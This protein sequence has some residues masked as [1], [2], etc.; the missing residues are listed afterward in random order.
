MAGARWAALAVVGAI[1]VGGVAGCG[2][3]DKPSGTNIAVV[4]PAARDDVDWSR[5]TTA[6]VEKTAKQFHV[7]AQVAEGTTD[8]AK[9]LLTRLAD[10]AQLVVAPY[11][12]DGPDAVAVATRT[13]VPAL[14]WGDP[15]A[16][17]PG[18][19]GDVEA[20][21]ASVVYGAGAVAV[22]AA[23]QRSVGI[24]ICDDESSFTMAERFDLAA[25]YVAG[26]RAAFPKAKADF[27]IA[28]GDAA[29]A[30]EAV[31]AVV[32]KGAQMVLSLCGAGAPGVMTGIEIA[33]RKIE[34]EAQLVTVIGDQGTINRE[35]MVLTG[36][37][38]HPEVAFA[39][40]IKDIRADRFG[41]RVYK[42]DMAN[43]GVTLLQTGRT[44]GDAYEVGLKV[45][46]QM[47]ALP[48]ASDE[49]QLKA[50]IDGSGQ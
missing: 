48:H 50:L 42:L 33:A 2:G 28:G 14:V 32:R 9:S 43:G 5:A 20:D 23:R 36:A 6:G 41:K 12:A 8:R 11:R 17:R 37:I 7:R 13:N 27:V 19:V 30:K 44:P 21:L 18:L 38:V 34:G 22:R 26:A 29:S 3:S 4:T 45:I 39:Q 47:G 25:A 24:V 35:N 15:K 31:I 40:A 16:A 49:T 10:G 46:K 1:A